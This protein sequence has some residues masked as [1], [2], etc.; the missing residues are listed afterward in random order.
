MAKI[1]KLPAHIAIIMDGRGRWAQ[2]RMLPRVTGHKRGVE[3][4]RAVVQRCAD[5][6]I[7]YLT[8]FAF[9]SENWQRPAA[10]VK[11][12]MTLL[13][14]LLENEIH[15]L[16]ANKV[17]LHVIG[18]IARL[19]PVLQQAIIN[20]QELTANNTN[21][22]LNIALNYGGRWDIVQATRAICAKVQENKLAI[23]AIDE[24]LFNSFV[25]LHDI[26]A[27]DLLIRTSGEQRISNF[28]LW[29]LAYTELYFC[30][31]L[32]P[33]FTPDDL[34]KAVEYFGSRER[35]FGLTKEQTQGSTNV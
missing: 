23:D 13:Q 9:S 17:K 7:H 32:W 19:A 4:T 12:L 31:T 2:K 20:A 16:H 27:P 35:R 21:L 15:E 33:D 25:S 11:A 26:P 28:L 6:K 1:M 30:N 8:L 34:D 22:Q 24:K 10:E 18:D 29:Q 14:N 5:L 3:A